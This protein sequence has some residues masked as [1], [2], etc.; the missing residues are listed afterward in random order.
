M[1]GPRLYLLSLAAW[2]GLLVIAV[3]NG[4]LRQ[5]VLA[6]WLGAVA[7]PVSGVTA[8]VAFAVAIGAFVAWTRPPIK[9][10]AHIGGLWLI[11]TLIAE[12]LMTV[13]AGRPAGEAFTALLPTA[14]AGGNLMALLLVVTT[15]APAAFAAWAPWRPPHNRRPAPPHCR[16]GER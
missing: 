15:L 2:F 3:L 9:P 11:L 5:L 7:L 16:A 14:I 6:P 8:M 10:A 4:A 12:T 1:S 13:A